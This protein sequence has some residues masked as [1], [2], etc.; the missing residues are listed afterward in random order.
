MG[1][2]LGGLAA[3][4]QLRGCVG[5]CVRRYIYSCRRLS[6]RSELLKRSPVHRKEKSIQGV[7]RVN[8]NRRVPMRR[9][10]TFRL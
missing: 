7:E 10:E 6:G 9:T 2:G 3:G 4:L 5:G 1:S 8:E